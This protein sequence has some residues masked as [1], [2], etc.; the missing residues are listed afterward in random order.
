MF[1]IITRS[2]H[3]RKKW[4]H[5]SDLRVIG[6]LSYFWLQFST[7]TP[8]KRFWQGPG[9]SIEPNW[10]QVMRFTLALR[11][12]AE[13]RLTVEPGRQK[14]HFC[15]RSW[16]WTESRWTLQ[17]LAVLSTDWSLFLVC[18]IVIQKTAPLL[19]WCP[20][21][22]PFSQLSPV[23]RW[24]GR[25][26]VWWQRC[27]PPPLDIFQPS[28]CERPALAF[29]SPQGLGSTGT[30]TDW[31]PGRPPGWVPPSTPARNSHKTTISGQQWAGHTV[32]LIS[33]IAH[34]SCPS[35]YRELPASSICGQDIF[36]SD[37][38]E[39]FAVCS[40]ISETQT[41]WRCAAV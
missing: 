31:Q 30:H 33:S 1:P 22:T 37:T 35:G 6:W 4:G 2:I 5:C 29:S 3:G 34:L 13:L 10:D 21:K 38:S 17:S 26:L 27:P 12:W 7:T 39:T 11:Q 9:R 25:S 41:I 15:L 16:R 32:C 40:V 8:K 20:G 24:C 18:M 19:S 36:E 23:Q 14:F 28:P